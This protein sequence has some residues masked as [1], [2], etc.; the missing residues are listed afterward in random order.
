MLPRDLLVRFIKFGVRISTFKAYALV[1]AAVWTLIIVLAVAGAFQTRL[2]F[3]LLVFVSWAVGFALAGFA[4]ARLP[5]PRARTTVWLPPT[6]RSLIAAPPEPHRAP[7]DFRLHRHSF[8]LTALVALLAG[9]VAMTLA[10]LLGNIS[11][12][13]SLVVFCVSLGWLIAWLQATIV[14]ALYPHLNSRPTPWRRPAPHEP[15]SV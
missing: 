7:R 9:A 3:L 11:G 2:L 12:G 6:M 8:A 5:H 15:M 4:R 1:G 13:V 14:R 10:L